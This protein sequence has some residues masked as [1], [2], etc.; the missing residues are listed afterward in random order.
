MNGSLLQVAEPAYCVL[1]H[2]DWYALFSFLPHPA[3]G[4]IQPG[5]PECA[6]GGD[7]VHLSP[8]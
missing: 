6:L 4:P 8:P 5:P 2:T 7:I 3:A 1:S